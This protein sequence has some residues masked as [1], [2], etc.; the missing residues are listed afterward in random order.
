MNSSSPAEPIGTEVKQAVFIPHQTN[1]TAFIIEDIG[2]TRIQARINGEMGRAD[3]SAWLAA[4][5]TF[6][7]ATI[8]TFV[9][10]IVTPAHASGLPADVKNVVG[11][12]ALCTLALSIICVLANW[13]LRRRAKGVAAD[14]C[15]EMDTYSGRKSL[16]RPS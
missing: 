4:A 3:I 1:R 15:D 11:I 12:I 7:G 9:V 8:A 6:A 13:T 10:W 5:F 14:I 2:Y 16:S